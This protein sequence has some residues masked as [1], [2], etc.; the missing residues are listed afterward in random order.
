MYF[1]I[2]VWGGE[3]PRLRGGEVRALHDGGLRADAA[4]HP[5]PLL[6]ARRRHRRLHVRPADPR[7]LGDAARG[8]PVRSCSWPSPW[9]S[10]SRCRCSRSTRGC[11]TPTSRRRRRAASSW[12]ACSS[13]WGRTGSC[14][15]ACRSSPTPA[16]PSGR[17]IFALAVIGI[18]YGAWVST[19]QPDL[20]KLVAYSSVS[21]L[22]FVML[23]IFTLNVQ[24]L[25]GAVIQMVNHGLSTGALFLM[26]GMLYER[27]HTPPHRRLRRAVEGDPRVLRAVPRRHALVGRAARAERVRRRVPDPS[28]RV[29]G[30]ARGWRPWPR[31]ASSSPR[32]TCCGCTSG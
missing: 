23:G 14:A 5:G 20:K 9:P 27:R 13:R 21:H 19:V 2:G 16:S 22:G 12:P 28:R 25:V 3:Q 30:R 1:M 29:P 32:S 11:P 15:S 18:I 31:P 26:V 17:W 7:A 4:G 6:P 8:G 24:G 10:R